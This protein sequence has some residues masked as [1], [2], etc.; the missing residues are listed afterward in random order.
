MKYHIWDVEAGNRLAVTDSES[1]AFELVRA[2]L[3]EGWDAEELALG[4]MPEPGES[5]ERLARGLQGAALRHHVYGV[6]A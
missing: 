2:F 4:A 1:E 5:V 6:P 3:D